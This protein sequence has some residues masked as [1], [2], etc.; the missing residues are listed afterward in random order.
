MTNNWFGKLFYV[1]LGEPNTLAGEGCVS[2]P[3]QWGN[4]FEVNLRGNL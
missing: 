1:L 4:M 2:V 3:A